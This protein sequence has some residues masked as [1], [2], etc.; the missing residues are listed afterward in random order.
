MASSSVVG[1]GFIGA[2]GVGPRGLCSGFLRA[3]LALPLVRLLLAVVGRRAL[4]RRASGNTGPAECLSW[5]PSGFVGPLHYLA[6]TLILRPAA[7]GVLPGLGR[8]E[9]RQGLVDAG[10][11]GAAPEELVDLVELAA[12]AG[13]R[14][15]DGVLRIRGPWRGGLEPRARRQLA[16]ERRPAF[17]PLF[18]PV[19]GQTGRSCGWSVLHRIARTRTGGLLAGTGGP[20]DATAG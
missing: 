5:G 7:G 9:A 18:A 20:L 16:S 2:G 17:R 15:V 14:R 1:F 8:S 6:E 12:R 13:Y 11:L 3:G 19:A 4:A 10:H